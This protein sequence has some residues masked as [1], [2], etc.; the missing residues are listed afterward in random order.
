[1]RNIGARE[2]YLRKH[3][4]ERL[5]RIQRQSLKTYN[6]QQERVKHLEDIKKRQRM[7]DYETEYDRLRGATVKSGPLHRAA[8]QRLNELKK[9]F[10]PKPEV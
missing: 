4:I 5:M 8:V 3:E 7:Q 1:M 6:A 9:M 10:A 2:P